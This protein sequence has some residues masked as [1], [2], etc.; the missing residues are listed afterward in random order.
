MDSDKKYHYHE[1]RMIA[2]DLKVKGRSKMKK[3]EL[4]LALGLEGSVDGK[5]L[6]SM[7]EHDK[8]KKYCA[9]SDGRGL[10][11]HGK[12]KYV[13]SDCDGSSMCEQRRQKYQC[14]VCVRDHLPTN[15]LEMCGEFMKCKVEDGAK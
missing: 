10:C 7:C 2:K 3:A 14:R 13:C 4:A 5:D 6:T 9:V 15:I 8:M 12:R 11:R 1:L